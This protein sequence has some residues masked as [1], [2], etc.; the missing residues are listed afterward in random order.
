[1]EGENINR[2][3]EQAAKFIG[4]SGIGWIIDFSI[5]NLLNLWV[6]NAIL[7]NIISS[8]IAVTFVFCFSSKKTFY[9]NENGLSL[10]VKYL[11][12]IVYQA[13]LITMASL[14]ISLLSKYI[15]GQITVFEL[16][17]WTSAI[18][19]ICITP[20]TMTLN[21]IVMKILIERI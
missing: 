13:I 4:I 18:S 15:L 14:L 10:E 8:G 17:R 7:S 21:F 9:K 2:L 3:L 5:F 16:T 19:K 6:S 12:Y 20:V 1:M 11:F